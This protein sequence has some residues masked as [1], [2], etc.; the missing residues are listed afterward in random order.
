MNNSNILKVNTEKLNNLGDSLCKKTYATTFTEMDNKMKEITSENKWF[1]LEGKYF[2][3]TF[4][5]FIADA[6]KLQ[7]QSEQL[8][9]FAK[10]MAADYNNQVSTHVKELSN[11]S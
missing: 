1:D 10:E 2:Q 3:E 8:G 7:E 5:S 6:K 9:N 4:S 11:I